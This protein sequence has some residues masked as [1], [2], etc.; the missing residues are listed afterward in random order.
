MLLKMTKN[1]KLIHDI[2]HIH[3]RTRNQKINRI[4]KIVN[5]QIPFISG[6]REEKQYQID[7]NDILY[8]ESVDKKVFAYTVNHVYETKYTLKEIEEI[9]NE[10]QFIRISKSLIVNIYKIN[11]VKTDVSMR[12]LITLSNKERLI[13]TRHY[14]PYL[15]DAIKKVTL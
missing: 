14:R 11:H 7:I 1:K 6:L 13:A 10:Q 3:Y 15:F 5:E 9:F 4:V 8:F 2:V 12:L